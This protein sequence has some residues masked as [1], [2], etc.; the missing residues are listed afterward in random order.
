MPLN[1]RAR[2]P[3]SSAAS[4][5]T[6]S[7][8]EPRAIDAVAME[9]RRRDRVIRTAISPVPASAPTTARISAIT[10]V[11]QV[12]ASSRAASACER[13]SALWV[14]SVRRSSPPSTRSNAARASVSDTWIA[15]C[16]CPRRSRSRSD[17][18]A[19]R[20]WPKARVASR[21]RARASS[22]D[23]NRPS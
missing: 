1:E 10:T 20:Y 5:G 9:S 11:V 17:V 18:T 22:L 19:E 7:L 23:T 12:L 16:T 14:V 13:S 21:S 2:S 3:I 4:A 8:N 15:R 6:G